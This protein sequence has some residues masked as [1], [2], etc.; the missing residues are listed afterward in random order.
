MAKMGQGKSAAQKNKSAEMRQLP[1]KRK[2]DAAQNKAVLAAGKFLL[3]IT[4]FFLLFSYVI[5]LFPL[6]WFEQ[7]YASGTLAALKIL[8]IGGEVVSFKDPVLV[9]LDAFAVPVGISY[10]CT[11]LLELTIVWAAVLASAGID[12]GKRAAGIVAGTI[13]IVLFNFA[14]IISSILIIRFFG[15][16]AG[17]FSHDLLFRVFLFVTIAG[18]YY[19][20]FRWA[21]ADERTAN[22]T[23]EKKAARSA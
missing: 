2:Q 21:A 20:W 13:A 7:F 6:A 22:K 4:A 15:L 19:F 5:S 11:G 3:G 9:K 12:L 23:V 8:G 10:L 18:F 14:R 16:D 17:I 1:A